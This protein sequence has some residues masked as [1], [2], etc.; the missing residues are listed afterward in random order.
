L[1]AAA[2]EAEARCAL[3][4]FLAGDWGG[5]TR[6]GADLLHIAFQTSDPDAFP[7]DDAAVADLFGGVDVLAQTLRAGYSKHGA[8][9]AVEPDRPTAGSAC[10]SGRLPPSPKPP[11]PPDPRDKPVKPAEPDPATAA[12]PPPPAGAASATGADEMD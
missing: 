4:S 1:A 11:P 7:A 9:F 5:V 6:L 8:R 10:A 12:P 2:V 3:R